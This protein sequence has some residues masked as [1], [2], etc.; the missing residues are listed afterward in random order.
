MTA[1]PRGAGHVHP[2]IEVAAFD[3]VPWAATPA[4]PAAAATAPC[5]SGVRACETAL[6]ADRSSGY[7]SIMNPNALGRSALRVSLLDADPDLVRWLGPDEVAAARAG[8]VVPAMHVPRGEWAPP[9]GGGSSRARHLGFLVLEGLVGRDERL[10]GWSAL[11]LVGP[12]ELVR[13]WE[14][15]PDEPLLPRSVTWRVFEPVTLAVLGPELE[16]AVA[17]WPRLGLA[18]ADRAL[19]QTSRRAT[20]QAICQLAGVDVRLLVL[21]WHLAERWGRVAHGGLVLPLCLRHETLGHLVGAKRPTVTLALQRLMAGG[22][23]ESRANATWFLK[24]APPDELRGL[25][26]RLDGTEAPGRNR[27]A[28]GHVAVQHLG[29]PAKPWP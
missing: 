2:L 16:A 23:V 17:R 19:R 11:A 22:F 6:L 27:G 14:Q 3:R 28:G 18:L 29:V 8:A 25:R 15:P 7:S 24:G 13:P 20:Q 26:I 5:A 4:C 1:R 10:A 21:F 12:G 9:G